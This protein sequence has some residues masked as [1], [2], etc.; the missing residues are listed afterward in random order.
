MDGGSALSGFPDQLPRLNALEKP[1]SQRMDLGPNWWKRRLR[2]RWWCWTGVLVEKLEF[3]ERKKKKIICGSLVRVAIR[4]EHPHLTRN[5]ITCTATSVQ[6]N[7]ACSLFDHLNT[8][9][10]GQVY[11]GPGLPSVCLEDRHAREW[12]RFR[13]F[14][15]NSE[16][17]LRA[18]AP[19][20]RMQLRMTR[21]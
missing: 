9:Q 15:A 8:K 21:R 11:C 10:S 4:D 7:P 16:K 17:R 6:Y 2:R 12:L 14:G 3:S 20:A 19:V 5:S 18:R 1:G 13:V